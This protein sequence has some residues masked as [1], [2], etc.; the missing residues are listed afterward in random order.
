MTNSDEI[1][2]GATA[3]RLQKGYIE[4]VIERLAHQRAG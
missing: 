1:L 4:G 2:A 3:Q